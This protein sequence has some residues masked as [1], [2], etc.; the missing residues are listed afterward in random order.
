MKYILLT[1]FLL[2]NAKGFA[3]MQ[4]PDILIIDTDTTFLLYNYPLND[5]PN[6][7]KFYKHM[8][9]DTS[10]FKSS[11]TGCWRG[12]KAEWKLI[13]NELYLSN[14]YSCDGKIKLN[15]KDIFKNV[16]KEGLVKADWVSGKY[17]IAFGKFYPNPTILR[18]R[19][20]YEYQSTF[21]FKDGISIN[22]VDYD[23]SKSTN[24]E[25]A[26]P[27]KLQ[28][29][30]HKNF[31]WKKFDKIDHP[32]TFRMR[33]VCDSLG[34]IS[35]INFIK[36]INYNVEKEIVKV[37]KAAPKIEAIYYYGIFEPYSTFLYFKFDENNRLEYQ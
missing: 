18:E 1:L 22:R 8:K 16:N 25:L 5:H 20:I 31:N 24:T 15:L 14:V 19:Y 36:S 2:I 28:E 26:S 11:S 27:Y 33:V 29:Y 9:K 10:F 17:E 23:N 13:N 4:T 3:T 37:L 34:Y 7:E 6:M 32:I 30:L 21:I 35:E 12:Y